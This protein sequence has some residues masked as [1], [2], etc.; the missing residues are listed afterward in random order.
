MVRRGVIME[1]ERRVIRF[2]D[3]L[4]EEL[5]RYYRNYKRLAVYII[6]NDKTADLLVSQ[7]SQAKIDRHNTIYYQNYRI[8]ID[9]GMEYLEFKVMGD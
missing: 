3:L 9:N 5:D 8:A 6:V 4:N 2:K 7:F 1:D